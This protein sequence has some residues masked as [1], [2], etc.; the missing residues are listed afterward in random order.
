MK[1]ILDPETGIRH[2]VVEEDESA[3]VLRNK[4]SELEQALLILL[5]GGEDEES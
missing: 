2:K 4:V 5:G 1:F 3:E